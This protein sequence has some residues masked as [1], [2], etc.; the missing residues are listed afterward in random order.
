MLVRRRRRNERCLKWRD[1]PRQH[2]MCNSSAITYPAA[3]L[4]PAGLA[5][6]GHDRIREVPVARI[7]PAPENNQLY[8]PVNADDPDI[9]ARVQIEAG[10]SIDRSGRSCTIDTSSEVGR[11]WAMICRGYCRREFGHGAVRMERAKSRVRQTVG[12]R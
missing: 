6:L 8:R 3:Q 10:S 1:I 11:Q 2:R 4:H 9:V 12:A 7:F 5:E